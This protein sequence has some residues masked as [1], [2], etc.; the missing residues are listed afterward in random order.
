MSKIF[1]MIDNIQICLSKPD[2]ARY[3]PSGWN[4]RENISPW[5]PSSNIM[6]ANKEDVL[7]GPWKTII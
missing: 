1:Q 7:G 4:S 2:E 3:W 5:C 6:G